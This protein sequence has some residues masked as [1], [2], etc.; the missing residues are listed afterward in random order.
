LSRKPGQLSIEVD[1]D[2][3]GFEPA[4]VELSGLR[5]LQDRVEAL[6]GRLEVSSRPGEGTTLRAFLPVATSADG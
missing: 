6:G 1:D 4:N 2:G 3:R 5:G